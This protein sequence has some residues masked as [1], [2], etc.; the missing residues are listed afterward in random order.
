MFA[1]LW[2]SY[3][4]SSVLFVSLRI[5]HSK[6]SFLI[7]FPLKSYLVLTQ[8]WLLPG[9]QE[10]LLELIE[11]LNILYEN[12]VCRYPSFFPSHHLFLVHT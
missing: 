10:V 4:L 9:Y 8:C 5:N 2:L 3:S 7:I 1:F 12:I 11:Q 6:P